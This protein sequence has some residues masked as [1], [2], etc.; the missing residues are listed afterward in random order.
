MFSA[1]PNVYEILPFNRIELELL[2][3]NLGELESPP[4]DTL[5][6]QQQPVLYNFINLCY[7]LLVF[8]PDIK[9]G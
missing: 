3:A 5:F 1:D 6:R 8:Q 4:G 7:I 2:V 9:K